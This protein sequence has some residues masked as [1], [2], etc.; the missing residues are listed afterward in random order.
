M[1]AAKMTA[2][3]VG[4]SFYPNAGNII[5]RL[6]PGAKLVLKR[7]P[8]NEF[9]KNAVAVYFNFS[10]NM[11]KLG[12]LSRGL[13]ELLAPKLDQGAEVQVTKAPII[14]GVITLEWDQPDEVETPSEN[15]DAL[16]ARFRGLL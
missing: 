2:N 15:V 13:A 1:S 9:D 8:N 7:E 11:T 4:S 14:G 6:R 5:A 16:T 3:I 12:H 10:G